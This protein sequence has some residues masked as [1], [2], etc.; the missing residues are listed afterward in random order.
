[1]KREAGGL[2]K[3][4]K[5]GLRGCDGSGG[6]PLG[7]FASDGEKRSWNCESFISHQLALLGGCLGGW[8]FL[9]YRDRVDM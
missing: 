8:L 7:L 4:S 1:M 2:A 6:G 5:G 3:G 9:A